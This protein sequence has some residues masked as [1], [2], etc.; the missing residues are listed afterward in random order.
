MRGSIL[1]LKPPGA[2]ELR[3]YDRPP[4]L[5]ELRLAIGGGDLELIQGFETISWYATADTPGLVL[6]CAAFCDEHGKLEHQPLNEL[7]TELWA[8][9]LRRRGLELFDDKTRKPKDWL[10]GQIA[11]VWGDKEFMAEL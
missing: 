5:E 9:A 11:V 2:P 1:V 3:E 4:T 8:D 6:R 10:V 7:A